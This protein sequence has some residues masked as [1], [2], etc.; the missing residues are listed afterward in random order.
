MSPWETVVV[1]TPSRQKLV[2]SKREVYRVEKADRKQ[3]WAELESDFVSAG[4]RSEKEGPT[5]PSG[6]QVGVP[7]DTILAVG[8]A[9][10]QDGATPEPDSKSKPSN[11]ESLGFGTPLSCQQQVTDN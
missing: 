1:R 4:P 5:V 9:H 10:D 7:E 3:E 8:Q 6:V 11:P 2:R